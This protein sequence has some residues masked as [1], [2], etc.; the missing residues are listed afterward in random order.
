MKKKSTLITTQVMNIVLMFNNITFGKKLTKKRNILLQ[1]PFFKKKIS[2][3]HVGENS[4]H[5][6]AIFSFKVFFA[7]YAF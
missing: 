4:S 7:F 6:D 3:L 2:T 1:M 5:F